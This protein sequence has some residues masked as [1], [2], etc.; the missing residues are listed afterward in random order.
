M[1]ISGDI[2]LPNI[3]CHSVDS[4]SGAN[5]RPFIEALH[6]HFLTQI[7][8]TPTCGSNILDLVVTSAPEHTKVTEVLSPYKAGAFTD[9]C[10]VL[11]EHNYFVNASSHPRKSV[12]DYANGDFEGLREALSAINLSSIVGHNNIDDDWWCWKDL[13][14]AAVKDF[15]P[16][17]RVKGRNPVP[18]IDSNILN[19]I[20]K[21][22]SVRQKLKSHPNAGLRDKFKSL[23]AQVKKLLRESR[24]HFYDSIDTGFRFNP[25]RLW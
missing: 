24:D 13:F 22:N 3:S 11:F 4:A 9:H 19:L 2:N 6:D 12:Y 16:S 8:N 10:V 17:K 15:V 7:N 1:V 14:L 25:K 5:E 18:W 20:K 21:K 23:W